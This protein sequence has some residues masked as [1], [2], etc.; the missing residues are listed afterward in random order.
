MSPIS[1]LPALGVV[2]SDSLA[3]DAGGLT[4]IYRRPRSRVHQMQAWVTH[5]RTAN[6]VQSSR[7]THTCWTFLL[8]YRDCPT[9]KV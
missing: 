8:W 3:L 7:I 1:D 4:R 9:K 6:L 2:A 5:C